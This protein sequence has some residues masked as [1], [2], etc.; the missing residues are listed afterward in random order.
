VKNFQVVNSAAMKLDE[1]FYFT[2]I[3]VSCELKRFFILFKKINVYSLEGQH[4]SIDAD[5]QMQA[6]VAVW[7]CQTQN[8]SS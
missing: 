4:V 8:H 7:R 2:F 6:N 3:V 1:F 5:P